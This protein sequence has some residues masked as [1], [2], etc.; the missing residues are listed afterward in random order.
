M[1]DWNIIA[2]MIPAGDAD[3]CM[4]KISKLRQ[5]KAGNGSSS[6]TSEED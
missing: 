2:S 1:D 5:V 4:L 3:A 6:W